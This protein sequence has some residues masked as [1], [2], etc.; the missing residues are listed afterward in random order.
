MSQHR[1]SRGRTRAK[2][3]R[4]HART[5]TPRVRILA[6]SGVL[7]ALGGAAALMWQ[8]DPDAT[9]AAASGKPQGQR[10]AGDRAAEADDARVEAMHAAEGETEETAERRIREE[11]QKARAHAAK[12]AHENQ[13]EAERESEAAAEEAREKA[14]RAKQRQKEAADAATSGSGGS[15]SGSSNSGGSNPSGS[16]SGGSQSGGSSS[17]G[18]SADERRLISL[19]NERRRALGLS[20]VAESA[21]LAGQAEECSARNLQN[22]TLTH[23]GHEVLFMGGSGNTP[24]AMIE[25]WFNSPGHKTALTYGSSTEAGAA[26]VTDGAGRLVAAINIDY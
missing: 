5:S 3:G 10:S 9:G 13:R 24:E 2:T 23:C 18:M 19:L 20:P 26:I 14:V 7:L 15:A 16:A 22:G 11:E 25:A 4:S 21:G 17:A 6:A 1:A 8:S 12:T